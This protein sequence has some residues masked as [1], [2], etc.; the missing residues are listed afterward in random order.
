MSVLQKT[1]LASVV[2]ATIGVPGTVLRAQADGQYPYP[3]PP[4]PPYPGVIV[5]G[6]SLRFLV[7]PKETLVFIDGY[8]SGIAYDSAGLFQHLHVP[9]GDHKITL[10][11]DGYK[12]VTQTISVTPGGT[13]K[14]HYSMERLPTGATSE[15]PPTPPAALQPVQIQPGLPRPL[16]PRRA[17]QPPP[18]AP[19][20]PTSTSNFGTLVIRVQPGGSEIFI[21]SDHWDGPVGDERLLIQVAEGPH[22]VE[23]FKDGF[24]RFTTELEIRRGETVPLNVSLSPDRD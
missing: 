15:P 2:A 1:I 23:I 14:L 21:D 18:P 3:Y 16:P 19:P 6:A 4:P 12:T 11:L 22:H 24:K 17:P 5:R 7:E 8:Y 9:P 13:Y 10:F 20:A